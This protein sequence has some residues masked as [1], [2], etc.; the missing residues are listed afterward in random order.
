VRLN[1]SRGSQPQTP[2]T[3]ATTTSTTSATTTSTPSTGNDYTGMRL[4]DAVAKIAQGRQQ[5]IVEYV[6]SS[7]KAGTVV[8]N[9][10]AGSRERLRVS[11]GPKPQAARAVPDVTGEDA[12]T[13]QQDLRAAGFSVISVQWPVSDQSLDGMVTYQTPASGGIPDGSAIVVYI[14]TVNG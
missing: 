8:S 2:T 10:K 6:T 14:G 3:S 5:A 12:A 9:A 11:A 7:E 13:A 4:S 1:V